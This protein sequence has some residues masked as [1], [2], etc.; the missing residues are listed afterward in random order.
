MADGLLTK[1][2]RQRLQGLLS[3]ISELGS[4]YIVDPLNRMIPGSWGDNLEFATTKILPEF[5]PGMDIRDMMAGSRQIMGQGGDGSFDWRNSLE[6]LGLMGLGTLGL[7]PGMDGVRVAGKEALQRMGDARRAEE[8]PTG[9]LINPNPSAVIKGNIP[10]IGDNGGPALFEP[11]KPLYSTVDEAAG[12]RPEYT[13]SAPDR[14]GGS[15]PR[16]NPKNTPVRMQRLIDAANTPDSPMLKVFDEKIKKGME[17][18]GDDWYNTEELRDW[19]V[20]ALGENQG[21]IEWTDFIEKIGA[22]STGSKVPENIRVASFYRALGNDAPRV[23]QYVL[24]NGGTPRA[25]SK[26]L[27]I[28]VPNMPPEKGKGAYQY[29]HLKQKGHAG[30]IV[31]QEAGKWNVTPPPELTGAAL[32][33]WLQANPKVKGFKN[34]LLGNKDNIAA[35][36]HFMRL[37]AMSDGGTDFLTSQAALSVDNMAKVREV[38]GKKLNKYI[39]E[40]KVNGKTVSSL[41]LKKAAKEGVIKDTK[42]FENMPSAWADVPDATEYQAYEQLAQR[43]AE[44]YDLTPA[45]FQAALWM[46]AGDL[47][48]LADA[49]QGT[50]M[51]LF[52]R[53][54]DKRAGER[55]L[56]RKDMLDDFIKNKA[57]LAIAPI[58]GA[59]LLA[60]SMNNEQQPQPTGILEY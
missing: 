37:L 2:N 50:F 4:D 56:S 34:S 47:T 31:N 18:K 49:S 39:V 13:G 41:N 15:Y 22:G 42:A 24:D 12:S 32:T 6:G 55:N 21:N 40:R 51:D 3:P 23:A 1:S 14:S 5:S 33:K 44:K 58:A 26:A 19:F 52:R 9:L 43:A 25:A 54:L 46:G 30:N 29:G 20:E 17:L 36:M 38:Y 16:Y 59:G 8:T 28:E 35:D 45:Q 57:P 60:A 48:N 7:I 10:R 53:S 27:G 11:T